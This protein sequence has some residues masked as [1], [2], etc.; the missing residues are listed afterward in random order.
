MI[1]C[2]RLFSALCLAALLAACASS[3]SSSLG[4]LPRTPDATIEQLLEQATS[5]KT[6]EKAALLRLS[7]ADMAFHQNNPGRSAQILAQVPLD[8]LK[9]AA[10]VF[11]STLTAE[12]A[13]TRN[14][15]KAAL[16][17]LGHPSLQNLKELPPEQ[18]I[19]TGTVHARAYEADG[20]TLAA[21]RERVAM[22]PLLTG[23]AA[24]SNH[25]A[26]W[27]L[28]A[29]VPGEQLQASG[30]PTLDGWITLAQAVKN[31]GTLEQQQAAID[32]WRAQNPA[33]PAAVQL[34]TPLTKLKELASQPLNKIALLLPQQ[35]PL[36]SVAKALRE[37]FMAAHYQA[38]Q[39]GQ[40]PPVI[41]VYDS[42]RVSSIDEFY[43]QAQADGVQ[44]VVGPLEKPLVKQLSARPQLPITTLALNY[45]EGDQGS[46]QLFQFGLAAEDEAREVSRRARADGLHRAAAMVPKGE[47]GERVFKAFRQDWE[48]NG[49]T[50]I[51][52][53]YV[54][55]PVALAQ[56]IADLFKLRQ[57]E[58]RAKSLQSTVGADVAAQ[59]SRRQDIEFIFLAVTPQQAQ[60]IKPTLNFQYAGDV[61]VYAT[62]HVFS[63]SGDK[64]QYNDMNGIM[65]CETPWLLNTTDPLRNQV[66]TQWPQ[67]NGSLGRLYAMG[68][69]AYRLA[70]RLGQLKA[71]PDTRIEGLSG[72]LGM[73]PSQRIERQMPWAKFVS[74]Q[75]E[76]LPDTPR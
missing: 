45:S 62:S 12:L 68:V 39:A 38:Q 19:R 1:A 10:Q 20:Q 31:A 46:A 15:P 22:A 61:P 47:W 18:Q 65:F 43:K 32:T 55:Q 63:A 37:G 51:G 35:G 57:S 76:R 67:A 69:D 26:I 64:N 72:N 56:Q 42:S 34:P 4:E 53:E 5:A 16:T 71:L 21:A 40:K 36:A 41:E 54:D 50:L 7:A 58:G 3:P 70:P 66:A 11:A 13:M 23:D 59:P 73:S 8:S 75:I 52:V 29:A 14:Q 24:A 44:L 28:I 25:D 17:A 2:L 33:H 60:Q 9:P 30:N 48:A 27:S 49:G 6:P 74:G